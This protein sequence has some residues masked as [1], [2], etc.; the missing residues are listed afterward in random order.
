[1]S[2]VKEDSTKREVENVEDVVKKQVFEE[3]QEAYEEEKDDRAELAPVND[4]QLRR[5]KFYD[6][7]D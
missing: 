3:E 6:E 7:L 1:M 5:K 4:D 2:G